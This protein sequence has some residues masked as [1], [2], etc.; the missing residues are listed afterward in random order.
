[1]AFYLFYQ[2]TH[3]GTE[4]WKGALASERESISKTATFV[5]VLDVNNAFAG[6]LTPDEQLTLKYLAPLGFYADFDGEDM[7]EILGQARLFVTK[8]VNDYGFDIEQGRYYFTGGRGC[9][10]EIPLACFL[11]KI[12]KDGIANLP[13]IFKELAMELYVDGLDLRVFGRRRMWRTPNVV[14]PNGKYKVQVTSVEFMTATVED[15]DRICTFSRPL[16]EVKEATNNTQLAYLF[17]TC[18]DKVDKAY[19]SRAKRKNQAKSMERFR[20]EWPDSVR[21]LLAG[22]NVNPNAGWNQIALQ[23]ASAALALQKSEDE[24]VAA[25]QPLIENHASD[26]RYNTPAKRER[27][28]RNQYRYQDGNVAYEFRI[29]GLLSLYQDKAMAQD[30]RAGESADAEEIEDDADIS[31]PAPTGE[32]EDANPEVSPENDRL[33][34]GVK[35]TKAGLFTLEDDEWVIKSHFGIS[36]PV[37]MCKVED[38]SLVGFRCNVYA[39]G[40]P[41]GNTIIS[42]ASLVSK[43]ALNNFTAKWA[44]G[45][46]ITD[47]QALALQDYLRVRTKRSGAIMYT[48]SCEGVDIVRPAGGE[49]VVF[50]ASTSDVLMPK[51]LDIRLELNGKLDTQGAFRTDLLDAPLPEGDLLKDLDAFVEHLFEINTPEVVAKVL[52]WFSASFLTQLVRLQYKQFPLLQVYGPAG[53]GKSKTIELMNQLHYW[54]SHPKKLSSSGQTFFPILV[55]VSQ[56]ASMPVIF[57][58]FKPREM[59]KAQKDNVM[60][61]LRNSYEGNDVERGTL[62]TEGGNKSPSTGR[63]QVRAPIVVIGEAILDQTATLERSVVTSMTKEGRLGRSEHFKYCHARRH[64]M[65]VLGRHLVSRIVGG[66]YNNIVA[67]LDALIAVVEEQAG[68]EMAEMSARPVFNIAVAALGLQFLGQGLSALFGDKYNDRIQNLTAVLIGAADEDVAPTQ[69]EAAKVLDV[70]AQ[71]TRVPDLNYKLDPR[72]DYEV[73]G[74]TVC[75]KLKAVYSKYVKYQ[76]AHGQEVLFDTDSA[77]IKAMEHHQALTDKSPEAPVIRRNKWEKIFAF[78]QERLVNEGIEPFGEH[79]Q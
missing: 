68:K 44:C 53:S 9:H 16:F 66:D 46:H 13:A 21:L 24:L 19:K 2:T 70:M 38:G 33:A 6:D 11:A 18:R 1:M 75:I 3:A 41:A 47:A 20:G 10:I 55:A 23:L 52:G 59:S 7:A 77:F 29:S 40:Q 12:P 62:V 58:E 36:D 56:S 60:N 45:V 78:S 63:F 42:A 5:T 79:E 71:L 26:G 37:R 14:R 76:K 30:I 4:T 28:L 57:E 49:P 64:M 34:R 74:D 25:S 73:F 15:Y 72:F 39:S 48:V 31:V 32:G 67:G 8:L 43:S 65:G 50:F 35:W 51:D 27:E 54:Q 69:S 17:S 22:E 61:V